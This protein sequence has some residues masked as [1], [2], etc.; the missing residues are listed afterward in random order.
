MGE[1]LVIVLIRC[2]GEMQSS[3]LFR[4]CSV[5]MRGGGGGGGGVVNTFKFGILL[6]PAMILMILPS[7]KMTAGKGVFA[8][9]AGTTAAS[10][11]DTSPG[12]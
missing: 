4:F 5:R 7:S 3:N 2:C 8:P 9:L 6:P 10:S 11:V 1:D 12:L